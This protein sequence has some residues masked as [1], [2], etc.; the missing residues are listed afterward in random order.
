[1]KHWVMG[2]YDIKV[3]TREHPEAASPERANDLKKAL[4]ELRRLNAERPRRRPGRAGRP[5]AQ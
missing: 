3:P 2:R 4:E 1:M 5:Q